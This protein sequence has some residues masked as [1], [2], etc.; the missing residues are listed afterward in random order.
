MPKKLL[1]VQNFN[2]AN[3]VAL[4]LNLFQNLLPIVYILFTDARITIYYSFVFLIIQLIPPLLP[5]LEC[6]NLD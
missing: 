1:E 4:I 5:N 3:A 2:F 6:M